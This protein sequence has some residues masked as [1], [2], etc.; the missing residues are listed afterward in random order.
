MQL[1]DVTPEIDICWAAQLMLKRYGD[2]ALEGYLP[3]DFGTAA[4][5]GNH[6]IVCTE[7]KDKPAA[8]VEATAEAQ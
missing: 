7:R 3:E 4:F 8:E 1:C 6:R 2:K 5:Y